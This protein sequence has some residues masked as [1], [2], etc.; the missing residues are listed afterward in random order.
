MLEGPCHAAPGPRIPGGSCGRWAQENTDSYTQTNF[1]RYLDSLVLRKL[2]DFHIT[3]EASG[4]RHTDHQ[5]EMNFKFEIDGTTVDKKFAPD[6]LVH[7]DWRMLLH[8]A[9]SHFLRR[10][11]CHTL[12]VRSR[13]ASPSSPVHGTDTPVPSTGPIALVSCLATYLRELVT[14]EE[15]NIVFLSRVITKEALKV[16]Y[17]NAT[18]KT[19]SARARVS[20]RFRPCTRR[21]SGKMRRGT[22][23]IEPLDVSGNSPLRPRRRRTAS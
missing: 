22:P 4:I 9:R 1:N 19:S 16:R 20:R 18:A 2:L 8:V 15:H 14:E 11:P 12:H 21:S 5:K 6:E 3:H 17:G 10:V 13:N 23:T 7:P